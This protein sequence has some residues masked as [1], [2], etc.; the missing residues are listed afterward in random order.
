MILTKKHYLLIGLVVGVILFL[1]GVEMGIVSL[2]GAL[3]GGEALKKI[4]AQE[5][6]SDHFRKTISEREV[7][8]ISEAKEASEAKESDLDKWLDK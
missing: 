2:F 3:L 4:K 5:K 1:R 6:E 7:G 8:I